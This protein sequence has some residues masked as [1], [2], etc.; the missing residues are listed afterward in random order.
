MSANNGLYCL[1]PTVA[2]EL[3]AKVRPGVRFAGSS[4][5]CLRLARNVKSTKSRSP[6]TAPINAAEIALLSNDRLPRPAIRKPQYAIATVQRIMRRLLIGPTSTCTEILTNSF[7]RGGLWHD[8]RPIIAM[9]LGHQD[10]PLDKGND[11]C[12]PKSREGC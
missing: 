4:Q 8:F 9:I 7:V 10:F 2:V 11:P 12:N 3:S 6:S 5:M 1:L